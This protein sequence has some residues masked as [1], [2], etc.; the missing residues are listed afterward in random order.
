[1]EWIKLND[2]QKRLDEKK[3]EVLKS[4]L[5]N[6]DQTNQENDQ[7]KL[8]FEIEKLKLEKTDLE[9]KLNKMQELMDKYYSVNF[10]SPKTVAKSTHIHS[11]NQNLTRSQ[12]ESIDESVSD[13]SE[14]LMD[15]IG[16]IDK[17]LND[18]VNENDDNEMKELIKHA[19]LKIKLK[20][21]GARKKVDSEMSSNELLNS[22]GDQEQSESFNT[23][24]ESFNDEVDRKLFRK[25]QSNFKYL[26]QKDNSKSYHSSNDE[27]LIKEINENKKFLI[28]SIN[29]EKDSLQVA[30]ELLDR[31]KKMLIKRKLMVDSAQHELIKEADDHHDP[32]LKPNE[33]K[34]KLR[35][36]EDKKL[37]LEKEALGLKQ[38]G[39]NIK[40]GKRLLKHKKNHLTQLESSIF[41]IISNQDRTESDASIENSILLK[42]IDESSIKN[43]ASNASDFNDE[44][45]L[46]EL[47][48]KLKEILS[49]N[50][51]TND[52]SKKRLN[53][54]LRTLPKVD[55]KIRK[56]LTDLSQTKTKNESAENLKVLNFIDEKWQKYLNSSSN[57]FNINVAKP[58]DFLKSSTS[59]NNDPMTESKTVFRPSGFAENSKSNWENMPAYHKLMYESG[60]RLLDQKWNQYIGYYSKN[61]DL[62]SRT[63]LS[64][65]YFNSSSNNF[66]S[67]SFNS[68]SLLPASTQHRIKRHRDWLKD[69]KAKKFENN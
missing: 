32:N 33:I 16:S 55:G 25:E 60:S 48:I 54:I 41:G 40:F 17:N 28:E 10:N 56:T 58:Q 51:D 62:S 3:T 12:D 52:S 42:Q 37:Y 46:N 19:K 53:S 67:N 8:K 36:L 49:I 43:M 2:E 22:S 6:N 20:Y 45:N 11:E 65:Q 31:Y 5:F 27:N 59:F 7:T 30:N 61:Y 39:V 66:V 24:D 1:M 13:G 69:F 44:K 9:T 15:K 64:S 29:K 63:I 35:T 14:V 50:N 4:K 34:K 68:A 26:N 21:Y 57:N 18:L 23:S 38:L 47:V